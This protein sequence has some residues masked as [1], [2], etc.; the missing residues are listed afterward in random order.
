MSTAVRRWQDVSDDQN[1]FLAFGEAHDMDIFF[2]GSIRGGRTNRELYAALIAHLDNHGTVLTEHIGVEDVEEQE[3][4]AGLDD[5]DIY[6]QDIAWLNQ[7]DVVIAEVTQ[8]SIGVGYE[9]GRAVAMDTPV[10]CL[11]HTDGTHACSA[12]IRGNDEVTLL[13][14]DT[15]DAAKAEIDTFC[16]QHR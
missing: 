13:E 14:Y 10:L 6:T 12:M 16:R 8:P 3:A 4:A 2:S 7:A 1:N 11:Y 5:A 15:L 9:I